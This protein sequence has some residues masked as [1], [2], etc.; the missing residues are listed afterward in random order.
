MVSFHSEISSQLGPIQARIPSTSHQ[1]STPKSHIKHDQRDHVFEGKKTRTRDFTPPRKSHSLPILS[2]EPPARR[3]W[4][5]GRDGGWVRG[6][7]EEGGREGAQQSLTYLPTRRRG[8]E[9]LLRSNKT[10]NSCYYDAA[11]AEFATRARRRK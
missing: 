6:R 3:P 8:E 4:E 9:R 11:P 7:G 5:R 1:G 2:S 10:T